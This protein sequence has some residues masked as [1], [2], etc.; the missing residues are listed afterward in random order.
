MD[1][2]IEHVALNVAEACAASGVGRTKLYE[3]IA[4]GRLR[5]RKM[6]RR[7]LI[8]PDDLKAFV[9]ALPAHDKK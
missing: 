5:A 8:L 3:A 6:G 2:V 4:A 7:T 9:A 1:K